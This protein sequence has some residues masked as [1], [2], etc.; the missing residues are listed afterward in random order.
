MAFKNDGSITRVITSKP[1]MKSIKVNDRVRTPTKWT[2]LGTSL[3][4]FFFATWISQ[5]VTSAP[6]LQH[7]IFIRI[8]YDHVSR[9]L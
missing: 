6:A 8:K 9:V 2:V 4:H 1:R 3:S 7:F 5:L